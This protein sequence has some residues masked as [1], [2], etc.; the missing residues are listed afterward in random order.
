MLKRTT[1]KCNNCRKMIPDE[2]PPPDEFY[3]AAMV[4]IE[5]DAYLFLPDHVVELNA[6]RNRT[7]RS[8]AYTADLHGLYCSERCFSNFI[9]KLLHRGGAKSRMKMKKTAAS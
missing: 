5:G 6:K 7:G 3:E 8:R 2:T 1:T 9:D 4:S